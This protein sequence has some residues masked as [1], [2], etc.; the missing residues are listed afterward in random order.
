MLEYA[1][2]GQSVN[3]AHEGPTELRIGWIMPPFFHELPL[4]AQND[5]EAASRLH[6][7]A[8]AVLPDHSVEDQ[9]IFASLLGSQVVEMVEAGVQ[10]AGLCF[11]E[12]EGHATASTVVMT[13]L[14]MNIEADGEGED[15][16]STLLNTL[17]RGY[18]RDEVFQSDLPCGPAVSRIGASAFSVQETRTGVTRSVDRNIIQTYVPLPNTA[19]MLL[20]ELSAFTP[21][22]WDLHSEVFAEILRTIDW[23]SDAEVA[24]RAAL[25]TQG[26]PV[27]HD[28]MDDETR[29]RLRWHSSRVLESAAVRGR[30][31]QSH[32]RLSV[33][34]CTDCWGKGLQSACTAQHNWRMDSLTPD[35]LSNALSGVLNHFGG[36]GWQVEDGRQRGYVVVSEPQVVGRATP[37][38]DISASVDSTAGSLTVEVS[39]GCR[40]QV[41][42]AVTSDF[43]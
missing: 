11:L 4:D 33:T 9:F 3:S 13:Q 19:E 2:A 24:A 20:F 36:Q 22:G 34:A 30:F 38:C 29:Q 26:K 31:L 17:M 40:R 10:Y 1:H 25:T 27:P 5:E 39:F 6:D 16:I 35:Q 12:H 43:G 15:E 42:T 8:L 41:H 23:A 37:A 21:D 18:P 7:L 28:G 14:P 32:D